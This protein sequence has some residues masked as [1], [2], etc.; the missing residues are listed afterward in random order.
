M[1]VS[2]CVMVLKLFLRIV[3]L[4]NTAAR[5]LASKGPCSLFADPGSQRQELPHLY[6]YNIAQ[7]THPYRSDSIR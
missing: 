6:L 1:R 3:Q 2:S 7:L 4:T 5:V